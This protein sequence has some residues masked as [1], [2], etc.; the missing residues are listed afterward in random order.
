MNKKLIGHNQPPLQLEDFLIL[1]AETR[2][3]SI[4]RKCLIN[5]GHSVLN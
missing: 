3:E 5:R 1:D 2:Y 4:Y